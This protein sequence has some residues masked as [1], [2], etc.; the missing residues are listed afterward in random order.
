M[1]IVAGLVA[2]LIVVPT[3]EIAVIL[4]VGNLIGV[5]WTIALLLTTAFLGAWLLRREGRH[6]Y[7]ALRTALAARRTPATE[8]AE[9]AFL[10]LGGLMMLLPGFVTDLIGLLL[11]LRPVRSYA[12][13]VLIR[14]FARRLPPQVANDVFGPMQVRS[15]RGRPPTP[16]PPPTDAGAAVRPASRIDS[17]R[18]IEG[19][20]ER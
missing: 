1:R 15:R 2:L 19:D 11:V 7:R 20:V 6:Y 8:A 12:A 18:V 5:G 17:Q 10:L 3:V 4:S 14:R 13:R 9:G 16:T